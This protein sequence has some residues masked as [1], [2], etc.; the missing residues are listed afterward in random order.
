[1]FDYLLVFYAEGEIYELELTRGDAVTIGSGEDD[2][3]SIAGFGLASAHLTV[4]S[5]ESGIHVASVAPMQIRGEQTTNR[6]L[7]VGDIAR[8]AEVLSMSVFEKRCDLE[9]AISVAGQK[10]IRLGRSERNDICLISP[11]VSS[12][13]A[14][15]RAHG[16]AWILED[17]GSTNRTFVNGE[18]VKSAQLKDNSSVFI[19]GWEFIFRKNALYFNNTAGSV[20][21]SP[22]LKFTNLAAGSPKGTPYPY[23]QRSP[24][25]KPEAE[26]MEADILPPPNRGAKPSVSW[27]SVLLPPAMMILVMV[28]VSFL[29]KNRTMLYYTVPM[30]SVSIFISIVNHKSQMKKWN[31]TQ[32]LAREKYDEHLKS[33]DAIITDAETRFLHALDAVNPSVYECVGI[34]GRIS[35]RLWERA[36]TDGD[37][38]EVRLGSS[39]TRS[40][41]NVKIPKPQLAIEEDPLLKEAQSLREKHATLTGVPA[42]HSFMSS[43]ITGLAG[44]RSAIKKTAWT[45]VM[46]VAAHHSYEDVKLVCVY[47]ESERGEW[48]WMRWLPHVWNPD[49]SERYIACASEDARPLLRE[50]GDLLKSRRRSASNERKGVETPIF[51]LLLADKSLVEDSGEQILPESPQ[52][53]VTVVYAYGDI[54][55]LPGEC[56]AIVNCDDA[57]CSLQLKSSA[58][59]RVSFAPERISRSLA[60]E[61]ARSLAPVRLRSSAATASMP[62]YIT[63]LQGYEAN[64]VED[65]DVMGRWL[66]SA[67]F[68]SIAA[69][70]GV[71]EN[72]ETF[73]FDI[74]EK[75][76]GPHGIVAGATRWGKSETLTT[77]LL[78]VALNFHPHEVSF[79]LIDFKG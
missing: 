42:T 6:M 15:I 26:T 5:T 25:L 49:R 2:S 65:L 20:K 14:V 8:V 41:V 34:A 17:L 50:M 29:M 7:S 38:L 9:G 72:G 69:P 61:F 31:E 33:M 11:Q 19:G 48:E 55:L 24:R 18:A 28:S 79:V 27:L 10:E 44:S 52:F 23:F 46:G 13:H 51:F 30:S 64:R 59:S 32:R 77:W 67:P 62:D 57:A 56:Q 71:R 68:K 43:T 40:N 45:I 74:H 39:R 53:G 58:A 76:M 54:G 60:D 47:P 4:S 1:M 16:G 12:K 35:R 78:S 70:L 63:F 21:L 22:K 75:G 36:V 73:Y 3:L 37:F 66:S